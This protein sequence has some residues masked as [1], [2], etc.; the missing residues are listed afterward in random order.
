MRRLAFAARLLTSTLLAQ[1]QPAT[2]PATRPDGIPKDWVRYTAN[3]AFAFYGPPHLQE[4][5]LQGIDTYVILWKSPAFTVTY[6][7]GMI[8]GKFDGDEYTRENIKIEGRDAVLAHSPAGVGLYVP[9]VRLSL[10]IACAPADA[11][12]A[13][14]LLK[15][16]TFGPGGRGGK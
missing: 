3:N 10:A 6:A 7:S 1:T 4:E 2:A 8:S 13:V 9:E 15:T 12:A 11:P 16:V 5:K 14:M